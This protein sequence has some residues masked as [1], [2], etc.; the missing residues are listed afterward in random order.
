[1]SS[2]NGLLVYNLVTRL[3][4]QYGRDLPKEY[5]TFLSDVSKATSVSGYLQPTGPGPLLI[6]RVS[7][8]LF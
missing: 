7:Y 4:Q 8:K 1:M 6:L 3:R 5:L 2:S